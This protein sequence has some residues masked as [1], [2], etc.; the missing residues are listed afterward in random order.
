MRRDH[1]TL[2]YLKLSCV[3][4]TVA[5]FGCLALHAA[6]LATALRIALQWLTALII[7]LSALVLGVRG[8]RILRRQPVATEPLDGALYLGLAGLLLAIMATALVP[9]LHPFLYWLI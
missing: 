2:L 1:R 7:I 4:L 6:T 5:W 9:S 3:V 8:W